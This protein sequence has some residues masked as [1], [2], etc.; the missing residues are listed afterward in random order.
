[1]VEGTAKRQAV[2]APDGSLVETEEVIAVTSVPATVRD[3]VKNKYPKAVIHAAER[4][5]RGTEIEYEVDLKNAP[6]KEIVLTPDGKILK[7]E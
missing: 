6:K 3:A 1:M 2:F 4:I 7:E 5:T